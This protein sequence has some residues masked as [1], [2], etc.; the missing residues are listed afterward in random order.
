L[1][2]KYIKYFTVF[3][4]I[5][6]IFFIL[7]GCIDID[8][9]GNLN[10]LINMTINQTPNKTTY[11]VNDVF[12]PAGLSVTAYYW[13]GTTKQVTDYKLS[14]PDMRTSGT[15][16]VTV[17]YSL[18]SD[19]F[20]I[21]VIDAL[22]PNVSINSIAI[23]QR[24][25]KTVYIVKEEFD[26][27]GL[28]IE[29]IY[30]DGSVKYISEY[31][32]SKPDMSTPGTKTIIINYF[33]KTV[34]FNITVNTPPP[35]VILISISVTQKPVK[36]AY[37]VNEAFNSDGLVISANYS[38]GSS[39][40]VTGYS[41]NGTPDMS[42]AGTKTINVNFEGKTAS[43]T[44]TVT[45]APQGKYL[46]SITVTKPPEKITYIV[47]ETF[48]SA[49]LVVTA[50]YSDGTSK[51]VNASLSTPDMSSAGTKTITVTFEGKTAVFNITVM[52][53]EGSIGVIIY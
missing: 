16:S 15:K 10:I 36:I 32:I 8:D 19:T 39:R 44:I 27:D 37:Y 3:L 51:Q 1:K 43:F 30:S 20:N 7:S 48:N 34:S 50:N 21:T 49:G 29:A 35:G 40:H 45:A 12:D 23:R 14:N 52:P 4:F 11:Y 46:T 17:S 24:P 28:V 53:D 26:S 2:Q 9:K 42:S 13:D 33:D 41:L 18:M 38:D 6:S 31:S 22:P 25:L 5:L 47:N